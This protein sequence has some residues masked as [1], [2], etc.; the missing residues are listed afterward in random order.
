MLGDAGLGKSRLA[1]EFR[2]WTMA[3]AGGAQW[4][5][6]QAGERAQGRPYGLLRQ[7]VTRRLRILDSDAASTARDKWLQAMSPLLRSQGDAAVLGH[8]LGL[9]FSADD[10]V[11]A[12]LGEGKQLRD[13]GYFHASQALR[14]LRRFV[15]NVTSNPMCG[16]PR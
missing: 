12:L 14:A 3:Q 8:L 9:D 16:Q 10:E 4:L 13:R 2:A 7:L 5:A 6:A 11:R 1:A 15:W